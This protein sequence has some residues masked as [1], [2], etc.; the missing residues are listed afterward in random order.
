MGML[1]SKTIASKKFTQELE[2]ICK[3]YNPFSA[4]VISK[5]FSS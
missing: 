2:T 1:M 5:Y 4:V 3:A